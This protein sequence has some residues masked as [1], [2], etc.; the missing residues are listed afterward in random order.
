MSKIRQAFENKKA[1]IPFLTAGDPS[2]EKTEEFILRMEQ[3]GADLI[4]IGIP[5]SDPT[6]EGVVIQDA[7][8]RALSKGF[9]MEALFEMVGRVREKTNIPLVFM[10]YI[11]P[12]FHYG[13]EAFFAK[14]KELGVDGFISPDL[15]FE[16]K[17]EVAQVAQKYDVD[18]ISM[19]SP[20]S[21]ERIT[22]IAQDATGFLY[23]VSS[24]G[25]TG[26]RSEIHTDLQKIVDQIRSVTDTPCAIGFGINTPEQAE[27]MASIADGAIVGSA[28]VKLIA[29][30]GEQADEKLYEYVSTMKE[31]VNR[32][33][34]S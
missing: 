15:P 1:F 21:E 32:P 12:V 20:T 6:A 24:M 16:E 11:N 9:T 5:F 17:Q 34:H 30:Y 13:Y 10:T 14:C 4:E 33:A 31:A 23:V 25:V 19:V 3:A 7:N 28:I 22:K 27:K 18:V 29:Q 8:I 26:V 2:L